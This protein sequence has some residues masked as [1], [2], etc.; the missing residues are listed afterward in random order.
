MLRRRSVLV[1]LALVAMSSTAAGPPAP[2]A[3]G[4]WTRQ[5]PLPTAVDLWA[6]DMISATS[7]W[8]VGNNGT[9]LHT[10][11]GGA[12]WRPQPSGTSRPPTYS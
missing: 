2:S 8:V 11:D 10:T 12:T 4:P 3:P 9:V 6:A 1:V 7:R 5:T